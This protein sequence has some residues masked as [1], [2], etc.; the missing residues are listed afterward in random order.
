MPVK[1]SNI[2]YVDF[3]GGDA[4]FVIGCT[5]SSPGCAHCY[6][7]RI[8]E[9]GGRD[10]SEVRVYPEKLYRLGQAKFEEKGV[11]FR[12]GLGSRPLMFVVDMGDM[13]HPFVSSAF[14]SDALD[15]MVGRPDVD[16]LVLTK[17][18]ARLLEFYQNG[19]PDNIWPGVTVENSDCLW[20]VDYLL[21]VKS[22][23]RWVS[24]E[25]MLEEIN[26]R[27]VLNRCRWC[28]PR[29]CTNGI[30]AD[31]PHAMLAWIVV[32]G[33]SGPNRRPFN[34]DWARAIRDQCLAAQVPFFY[35]QGSAHHPGRDDILDGRTWKQIPGG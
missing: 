28:Y 24:I 18:A 16:W 8:V 26:L 6:A 23:R 11:P 5:P 10:F 15:V 1:R 19:W 20:R 25:P 32:G 14:I 12:R 35:K 4:N 30:H 33:E 34:P 31:F 22:D 2:G 3:S 21:Q 9:R 13:F 17:R 27:P 29:F 7:R